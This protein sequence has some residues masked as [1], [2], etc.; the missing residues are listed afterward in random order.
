MTQADQINRRRN[1]RVEVR[2]HGIIWLRESRKTL[3][4]E[5]QDVSQTGAKLK[6][7]DV[8]QL[9]G[10]FRLDIERL[11]FRSE[12]IVVWRSENHVGVIFEDPPL[13]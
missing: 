8:N 10:S 9:P 11:D 5:V 2:E 3:N 12:C 4:C 1:P 13:L 7:L 6:L